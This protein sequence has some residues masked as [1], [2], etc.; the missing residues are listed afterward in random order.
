MVRT[1]VTA[2]GRMSS[3]HV[4]KERAPSPGV[5]FFSVTICGFLLLRAAFS[6]AASS[7]SLRAHCYAVQEWASMSTQLRMQGRQ[8]PTATCENLEKLPSSLAIPANLGHHELMH[9]HMLT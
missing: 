7:N 5:A 3:K 9:S 1:D 2:K 4:S 6:V 8:D